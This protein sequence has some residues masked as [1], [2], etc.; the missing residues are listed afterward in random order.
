MQG[1]RRCGGAYL[2]TGICILLGLLMY[3]SPFSH[4]P[5]ECVEAFAVMVQHFKG[6]IDKAVQEAFDYLHYQQQQKAKATRDA[7]RQKP[8]NPFHPDRPCHLCGGTIQRMYYPAC[9]VRRTGAVYIEQ[10]DECDYLHEEVRHELL[11]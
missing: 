7:V 11:G 5:L 4:Y 2:Q 9:E 6:D 8:R 1:P 3:D 10:C